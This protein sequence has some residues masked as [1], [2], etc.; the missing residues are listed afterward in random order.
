MP[1]LMRNLLLL[2]AL[3]AGASACAGRRSRALTPRPAPPPA[4]VGIGDCADPRRDGVIGAAPQPT[5]ADRD[6]DGD[7]VV[8]VVVADRS[9]CTP[10]GNCHWNIFARDAGSRCH[11]YLGTV[12]AAAIEPLVERGEDGYRTLRGWWRFSVERSLVQEYRFVRG[13]YRLV[14]ALLCREAEGDRL[15]CA[16]TDRGDLR[17]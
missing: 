15:L 5:R 6:L 12:A 9:M 3:L 7:E 17:R 1:T 14:E 4:T 11:R 13:G 16:N 2:L 10:E 8:E